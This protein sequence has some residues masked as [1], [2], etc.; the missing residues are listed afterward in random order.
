[1]MLR[2]LALLTM[3]A[4]GGRLAL[5]QSHDPRSDAPAGASLRG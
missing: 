4:L 2:S 1:M 3:L 5:A